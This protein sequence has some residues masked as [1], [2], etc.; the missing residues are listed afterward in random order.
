VGKRRNWIIKDRGL[1]A[2]TSLWTVWECHLELNI[3]RDCCVARYTPSESLSPFDVPVPK[4]TVHPRTQQC[5]RP[6]TPAK[7][8]CTA[9]GGSWDSEI[10]EICMIQS[11]NVGSEDFLML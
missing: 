5:A 9:D 6:I 3:A 2:K 8:L 4:R 7:V 11:K 1:V 10:V